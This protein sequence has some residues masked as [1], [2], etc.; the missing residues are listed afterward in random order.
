[1]THYTRA[2]AATCLL[3]LSAGPALAAYPDRPI[4]LIVPFPPGGGT[5]AVGRMIAEHMGKTLG[6]PIMVE[7][8]G[9]AGGTIAAKRAARA[10]A[11]G[12]TLVMGN[13]GTHGAAPAYYPDLPYDP[14]KDFTP[15]GLSAGFPMLIVTRKDFP[16]KTLPEFI[17]YTRKNQ[18]KVNE[19]HSGVG[20]QS[21]TVCTLLQ[22]ILG[23]RTGRLAYRGIAPALNDLI[24]GHVDFEC[25]G[26]GSA[27]PHIQSGAIK[28][29]AIASP[30]RVELIGDVPTTAEGGLP[31][32][33]ASG[34]SAMFAPR[35][36]PAD[37][38]AR[39]SDALTKALDD[40][41]VRSR[42]LGIGAEIPE[43]QERTPQALQK[44][45]ESEIARWSA[46]LKIVSPSNR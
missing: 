36:L 27:F 43:A 34:W 22:S 18:T 13:I 14:A 1:M 3:L 41:R 10:P 30:K 32:F 40:E 20:S 45:V 33:R 2:I 29:I 46:A 9:G 12:Y 19:A 26:L 11:D 44:L 37:V 6:Q 5:D 42:L 23:I 8:D 4:K 21:H 24:A 25:L 31:Q 15:I 16:A 28:A 7:N 35:N 39:L 38:Q 17:D